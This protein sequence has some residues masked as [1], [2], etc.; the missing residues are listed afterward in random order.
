MA[1]LEQSKKVERELM[2]SPIA[3]PKSKQATELSKDL[4]KM[5]AEPTKEQDVEAL[6]TEPTEF[7][8]H[9]NIKH[10][11]NLDS[12]KKIILIYYY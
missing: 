3:T 2:K 6:P 9:V 8:C 4:D 7:M 12:R 5:V 11:N 1:M 10:R